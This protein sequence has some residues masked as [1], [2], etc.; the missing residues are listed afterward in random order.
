MRS[1]NSSDGNSMPLEKIAIEQ[2]APP[3]DP[4]V[5]YTVLFNPEEYTLSKNNN[6]A[7]QSIPGLSAP[8]LQYVAGNVRTLEM[9]LFFDTY[10]TANPIK[11]DVRGQTEKVA[12]LMKINPDL[13]APPILKVSW[14]S[15]DFTCVL[16]RVSQKFQM[17]ADDGKPV[18]A[19]LNVTFQE[20]KTPDDQSREDGKQTADFTKVHIVALGDTL[21]ALAGRYYDDPGLWRP[22][23]VANAL[24]DPRE[25]ETGRE[26]R[27]PAL[28]FLD[29]DSGEELR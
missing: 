13:H 12:G 28:P 6:F 4:P 29:P 1:A 3:A 16:T 15:L 22:I 23:A 10:D 19:R 26:L 25:I 27:V 5:K 24:D 18:R 9:E 2:I 11:E 7:V 20:Y 17:F 8:L 21:S 14:A